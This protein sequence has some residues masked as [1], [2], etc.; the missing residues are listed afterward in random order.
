MATLHISL[1]DFYDYTPIEIDY[2]LKSYFEIVEEQNKIS[3][4]QTRLQIYYDYLLTPSKKRK[5]TYNTFKKD[6]LRFGFDNEV[7]NNET[8]IDDDAF[9]VIQDYFNKIKGTQK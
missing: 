9:S 3:W 5:V 8:I 2:A 4:E 1:W 6:Y 7:Y